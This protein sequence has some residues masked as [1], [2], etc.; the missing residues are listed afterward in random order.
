M[1]GRRAGLR[2]RPYERVDAEG[3][4]QAHRERG[5][6]LRGEEIQY[7]GEVAGRIG[8]ILLLGNGNEPAPTAAEDSDP[9]KD[10][11]LKGYEIAVQE[12]GAW[13]I[14]SYE[15]RSPLRQETFA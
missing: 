1:R 15:Q 11:P 4:G 10:A 2:R 9:G 12:C 7:F 8:A 6:A 5:R 14:L 13:V 3:G